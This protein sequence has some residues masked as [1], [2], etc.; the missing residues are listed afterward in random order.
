MIIVMRQ[1]SFCSPPFLK[2]LKKLNSCYPQETDN[3]EG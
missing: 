2:G 1:H 3:L